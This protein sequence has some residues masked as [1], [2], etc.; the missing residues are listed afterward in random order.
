MFYLVVE[1][2]RISKVGSARPQPTSCPD[3]RKT[4]VGSL[5]DLSP[6][7]PIILSVGSGLVEGLAWLAHEALLVAFF[8]KLY[9]VQSKD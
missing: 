3:G 1:I 2:D 9:L 4:T 8:S 5:T 6:N 7:P